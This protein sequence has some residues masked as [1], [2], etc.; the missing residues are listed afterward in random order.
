MA[1]FNKTVEP[2]L[3]AAQC[4]LDVIRM[5]LK[6]QRRRFPDFKPLDTT[7]A[8]HAYEIAKTMSLD[9]DAMVI[10]SGDGLIHEVLNGFA[11]HD[12]PI[13]AFKIPL[14]PVPTG[15]G[16]G[17]SLNILGID[18]RRDGPVNRRP[19]TDIGRLRCLC[20]FSEH[21]QR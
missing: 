14:A 17:L 3:R 18:V 8:G 15:T 5:S 11:H 2:I 19:N 4:T 16:N 21:C 10:V 7:R 12:Q 9:C 13:N 20:C 1:I 6:T